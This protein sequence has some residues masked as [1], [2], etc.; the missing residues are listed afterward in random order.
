[1]VEVDGEALFASGP[2]RL[3]AGGLDVQQAR[4]P[5]VTG[6]GVHVAHQGTGGRTIRQRGTLIGDDVDELAAQR[7]AIEAKLDGARHVLTDEAGRRWDA[8]MMLRFE[9][10]EVKRVGARWKVDYEVTY[11][12]VRI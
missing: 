6:D 7:A 12:Q 3:I 9:P 10:A 8:V 4:Q 5:A 1:M 2:S 11:L